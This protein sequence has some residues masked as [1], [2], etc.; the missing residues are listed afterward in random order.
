MDS[1][2]ASDTNVRRTVK[3]I[4]S[5]LTEHPSCMI[6]TRHCT[7]NTWS[8][9]LPTR[10]L[11]IDSTEHG[12]KIKLYKSEVGQKGCYI[13][14]SHCWG[15][16]HIITTTSKTMGERMNDIPLSFL[17]K[18]FQDAVYLSTKLSVQY[19]W[20]DS[21]CIIQDSKED[22]ERESSKM[23]L[24]YQNAVLTIAATAA[25]NG[26]VGCFVPRP[27]ARIQPIKIRYDSE[28]GNGNV[29]INSRAPNLDEDL[30]QSPLN[31]RAWTLQERLLSKRILHC[32]EGQLYWE[33]QTSCISEAGLEV[34]PFLGLPRILDQ[35]RG[36]KDIFA[37]LQSPY[38]K[39]MRLLEVYTERDL[40]KDHDKLPALSGLA[41]EFAKRTGDEYLAGIWRR[42]LPTGLLWEVKQ[43]SM[44]RRIPNRAP[45]WSWASIDGR[46]GMHRRPLRDLKHR[47]EVLD[48]STTPLGQDKYG[49]VTDGTITLRSKISSSLC[50][51]S[52][53][54][55]LYT[56]HVEHRNISSGFYPLRKSEDDEKI[57]GYFA[58][59]ES[60]LT[61]SPQQLALL[62][63]ESNEEAL[64]RTND[65]APEEMASFLERANKY[66]VLFIEPVDESKLTYRRIGMGVILTCS[67]CFDQ[68]I[69]QV[70]T[71]I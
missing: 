52:K 10:L 62:I 5:C 46:L 53:K 29:Y 13:A 12:F 32:C 58:P 34:P 47:A 41:S 55:P 30:D 65:M 37:N 50:C 51:D 31:K 25:S 20:I 22:W 3:W 28:K 67:R 6:G 35:D 70:I 71:L 17:S 48:G 4:Q 59:D 56:R 61:P 11:R 9:P 15:L 43:G 38:W 39:W 24:V 18:T 2:A 33:C 1:V 21:L 66:V 42:F 64:S 49:Q 7:L 26:T 60:T 36:E 14:L 57:I 54:S 44:T 45:S 23:G 8:Q 16:Q 40:T 69:D 27:P 68:A 63:G 19:L